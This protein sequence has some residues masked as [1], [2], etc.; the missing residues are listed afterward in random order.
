MWFSDS[1]MLFVSHAE[2]R[3]KLG[4]QYC[5]QNVITS[6]QEKES[7]ASK[8]GNGNLQRC[9]HSGGRPVL[10]RDTEHRQENGKST[11]TVW[12]FDTRNFYI[13]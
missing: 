2:K 7:T 6:P 1:K 11:C 10:E 8:R 12:R 4:I 3:G 9:C 5:I 13:A